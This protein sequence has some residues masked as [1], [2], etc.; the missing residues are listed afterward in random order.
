MKKI[1]LAFGCFVFIQF[2]FAQSETNNQTTEV[3]VKSLQFDAESADEFKDIKWRDIKEIFAEN[4]ANDI[5]ELEFNLQSS[6][7]QGKSSFKVKGE[8]QNLK[9]LIKMAKRGVK[10]L[11]KSKS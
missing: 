7:E 3:T 1:I 5:V 6:N 4:D 11:Y 10:R 8:T 2:G 9:R